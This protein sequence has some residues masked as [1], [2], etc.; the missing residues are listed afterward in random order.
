MEWII[1]ANSALIQ[2]SLSGILLFNSSFV[3]LEKLSILFAP[4]SFFWRNSPYY[5]PLFHFFG[6]TLHTIRP[7][8]IF[9]EK[10]SILFAPIQVYAVCVYFSQFP[11]KVDFFSFL[12]WTA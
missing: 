12:V 1:A 3:F 8:F 6:E 11:K 7:Y 4:I 2:H 5:S 9:L 10:L